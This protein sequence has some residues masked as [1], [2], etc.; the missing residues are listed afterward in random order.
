[1]QGIVGLRFLEVCGN[2]FDKTGLHEPNTDD[3]AEL[4]EQLK[5][6]P[7]GYIVPFLLNT[8]DVEPDR[9]SM[10]PLR[11]SLVSTGQSAFPV[12]Y[13]QTDHLKIDDEFKN[14]Y[15]GKLLTKSDIELINSNLED[16]RGSYVNAV[17]S[18]KCTQL[19]KLSDLFGINLRIYALRMPIATL[20]AEK[21]DGLLHH[22][23]SASH[24]DY[25]AIEE[26][27]S[28]MGRSI[29]KRTTL[30][31]IPHSKKGYGSKRAARGKIYF[32]NNKLQDIKVKYKTTKLYPNGIDPKDVSAAE[33]ND[34]FTVMGENLSDYSFIET[35]SSPQFF[36][37]SLGSP[38]DGALWHGVGTFASPQLLQSY[39][40][41]RTACREG[42][43]IKD[44]KEKYNVRLDVPLQFNL[45][46]EG[47][48]R[49]PIYNNIDASFGTIENLSDLVRRG[50]KLE[51]LSAYK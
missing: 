39:S 45:V 32:E 26:A 44:L 47:M 20:Q 35:P 22:I 17:D 4:Q 21:K 18:I 40:S 23:I 16:A 7:E 11:R 36:L 29:T 42:K 49:H 15:E 24:R 2:Y 48:W 25:E 6:P 38:E 33:A 14:K 19:E 27:Y 51:Y 46:P 1:V 5:K 50:M 8:D 9:Y 13:V 12:A 10:N 3:L 43:M 31:T 37:Y 34:D 30:L 28:C 41:A